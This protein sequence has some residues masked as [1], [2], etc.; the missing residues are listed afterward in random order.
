MERSHRS[1]SRRSSA[2]RSRRSS[3]TQPSAAEASGS[4][5]TP[6]PAVEKRRWRWR[7]RRRQLCGVRPGRAARGIRV[8]TS[9]ATES[10]LAVPCRVTAHARRSSSSVPQISPSLA[11]SDSGDTSMPSDP[12]AILRA[13]P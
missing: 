2:T 8:C 12:S 3:F 6:L 13:R 11:A 7:K 9:M 4:S 5:A 1:T 10:Q